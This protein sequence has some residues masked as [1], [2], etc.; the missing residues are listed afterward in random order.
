[1]KK[2]LILYFSGVGATKT[3][4]ELMQIK[5]S[6]SYNVDLISLENID[7]PNI[8]DYYALIIDCIDFTEILCSDRIKG[9]IPQFHFGSLIN[10]P[11]KLLGRLLTVKIWLHKNKCIKCGKCVDKCP[12]SVVVTDIDGYPIHD[13]MNCENCYRCIH[14]CPSLALSLNKTKTPGKVLGNYIYSNLFNLI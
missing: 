8:D 3:V 10:A 9:Y 7:M 12:H 6:Q 14:H 13:S 4:A 2:I 1:M 11:N 5:L